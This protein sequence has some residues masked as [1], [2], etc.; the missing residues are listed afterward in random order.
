MGL[1]LQDYKS[2]TDIRKWI[3]ELGIVNAALPRDGVAKSLSFFDRHMPRL[4]VEQASD[5]L[6]AMDLSRPVRSVMLTS[7]DR[8]I[9]FRR[10]GEAEFKLFYCRSGSSKYESGI[11]P[12][13]R[14]VVRFRVRLNCPALESYSTGVIDT[15]SYPSNMT[16][17]PRKK[18]YGY[19]AMGGG[20][21]LLIPDAHRW[22]EIAV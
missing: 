9:A 8:V 11:N 13:G 20:A 7:H 2:D 21:Q 17:A 10:A 16:I 5:F 12:E 4:G 15:W 18:S 6:R 22:L 19:M 3:D 14:S 1:S